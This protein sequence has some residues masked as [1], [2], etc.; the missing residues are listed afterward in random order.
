MNG[1]D[2]FSIAKPEEIFEE[3]IGKYVIVTRNNA[4][5]IMGKLREIQ[6]G[7]FFLKPYVLWAYDSKLG[8]FRYNLSSRRNMKINAYATNGIIPTTRAHIEAECERLSSE[9]QLQRLE[10][11]VKWVRLQQDWE[12]IRRQSSSPIILP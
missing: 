2:P 9:Y 12:E 8:E 1:N 10:N 5:S 6:D 7:H 11:S 4:S 3:D